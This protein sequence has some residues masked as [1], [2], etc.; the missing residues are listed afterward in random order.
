MVTLELPLNNYWLAS[1]ARPAMDDRES[2]R[3]GWLVDREPGQQ[4]GLDLDEEDT[5]GRRHSRYC[6]GSSGVR[7]LRSAETLQTRRPSCLPALDVASLPFFDD[8]SSFEVAL[9]SGAANLPLDAGSSAES[10]ER[11]AAW[12]LRG[13]TSPAPRMLDRDAPFGQSNGR[14]KIRRTMDRHCYVRQLRDLFHTIVNMSTSKLFALAMLVIVMSWCVQALLFRLVSRRCNLRTDTYLKALYLAIETLQTIGYGVEDSFF[15]S[16]YSGIFILG[17]SA[18]WESLMNAVLIAVIYTRVSRPQLRASSVC[19]S[20]NAVISKIEGQVYFMFQV[21]DLRKHQLV[22]A[23]MRLYCI[24]HTETCSGIAFQ[25]RAMRLQHPDDD[26][27]GMLF[28]TLP[29][30]VIH[31]VD[32]WSPLWPGEAR[33]GKGTPANSCLF[34]DV[35]QRAID[36][37]NG[38][39]DGGEPNTRPDPPDLADVSRRVQADQLEI[40]CIVEGIDPSTSM[41]LQCRHSYTCDDVVFNAAFQRCVSRAEDGTCEIDFDCFHELVQ[42]DAVGDMVQSLA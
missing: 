42:K 23:H 20:A 12:R 10:F 31:R 7:R 30:L 4:F 25:T 18:L 6:V 14:L 36:A 41:T 21:C 27:G 19:F 39:R 5:P 16:C 1:A 9:A 11:A 2:R 33:R 38:N 13:Y 40:L 26:L 15:N 34:P 8:L 29:Q 35:P 32:P 22:E 17:S 37:E 28:L 3:V 24:Q